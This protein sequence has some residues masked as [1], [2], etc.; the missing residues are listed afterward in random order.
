MR[1]YLTQPLKRGELPPKED[2]V[3]LY[4]KQNKSVEDCSEYF[5]YSKSTFQRLL[6]KLSIKKDRKLVYQLQKETLMKINGVENVFQLDSVKKKS[7]Q[8]RLEKYGKEHYTQT[9]EYKLK[10]E[11]TRRNRYGNDLYQREKY[12]E[13]CRNKWGVDN[14]DYVHFSDE[15]KLFENDLEYTKKFIKDN[16][17]QSALDFSNKTGMK[18]YASLTLLHRFDLMK[19]FDYNTSSEE[20][21]I[22]EFVKSF[23]YDIIPHYKLKNKQEIDVYIPELKL[24]IEFNGDYWH[25]EV[26]RNELYHLNKSLTAEKEGIFIYHIFGYEWNTIKDKIKNQLKNLLKKNVVKIYARKCV[27]RDVSVKDKKRFLELNHIQGNDH[28]LIYYGLYYDDELVS[29]MTF[30]KPHNTNKVEWELSRFCSKAGCNV[31]GGANKLFK[32]FIK[33]YSPKSVIS[34]SDIAKTRGIL[35]ETLGFKNVRM[36][37]PS[38]VWFGKD[39]KSRYQTRT[40]LLL[41]KGYKG[42]EISIMH[43]LGYSRIFNCGNKV[44]IWNN[45][46][47][48]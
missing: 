14:Y 42:T 31:V 16:D 17:V 8:T 40:K 11:K 29:L 13:T 1:D 41:E 23:G 2:I 20:K 44:W 38:Y 12:K 37:K 27:I 39:I 22:Q 10:N 3:E 7:N 19:D 36:S 15:H 26:F 33:N 30:S 46:T 5:G 32:K 34:Y 48:Q 9:D 6:K 43:E 45:L 35:Y 18:L 28:S 4:I 24:G 25:C 47:E 21:E